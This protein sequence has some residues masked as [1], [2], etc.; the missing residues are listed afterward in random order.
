MDFCTA[1]M[2]LVVAERIGATTEMFA[3]YAEA[4][5]RRIPHPMMSMVSRQALRGSSLSR[6]PAACR[7]AISIRRSF[8]NGDFAQLP[9]EER[10][11]RARVAL[12]QILSVVKLDLPPE[13]KVQMIDRFSDLLADQAGLDG[14]A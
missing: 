6:V 5:M 14:D 12:H 4:H 7:A 3:S 8:L 13:L 2:A 10:K 11:E 1:Q 9:A